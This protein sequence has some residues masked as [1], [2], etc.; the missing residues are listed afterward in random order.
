MQ[1]WCFSSFIMVFT[2]P[3]WS[4]KEIVILPLCGCFM[5][6]RFRGNWAWTHGWRLMKEWWEGACAVHHVQPRERCQG[7]SPARWKVLLLLVIPVPVECGGV[8]E[9]GGFWSFDWVIGSRTVGSLS[10]KSMYPMWGVHQVRK[11]KPSLRGC[12]CWPKVPPSWSSDLGV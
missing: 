8:S 9:L 11:R 3:S 4:Q 10:F 2:N 1:L 12:P 5:G 7:P 6:T